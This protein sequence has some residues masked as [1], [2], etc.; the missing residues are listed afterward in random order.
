M[1][2]FFETIFHDLPDDHLIFL[3]DKGTKQSYW[4]KDI[5]EAV[6]LS[7]K[8]KDRDFYVGCGLVSSAFFEELKKSGVDIRYKRCPSDK[9]A[10]IPAFWID[11]DVGGQDAPHKKAKLPLT[12]KDIDK[13]LS[14]I[15]LPPTL[16]VDSGHGRHCWWVLKEPW[17]F[18]SKKEKKEGA[19]LVHRFVATLA[20]SAREHGFEL[21]M[22]HD[23][24][25]LL[26]IPGTKNT[27][28]DDI[29]DVKLIYS[30]GSQYNPDD[31]DQFLLAEV[32]KKLSKG[33]EEAVD[34]PE[35][36]RFSLD[37][38]AD[39]PV[40]KFTALLDAE[41]R[42]RESWNY[43]RKD[44]KDT[45][46]SAYDFSLVNFALSAGWSWQ[47]AVNLVIAFRRKHGLD[48]KLRYDYYH[49]TLVNV[50]S[51]LKREEAKQTIQ[52]LAMEIH[53][54]HELPPE[55]KN[56][57]IRDNLSTLIGV[58]VTRL[59]KFLTEPPEY[60]IE[61]PA[62]N[63][64]LGVIRNITSQNLFRD[65]IADA[66]KTMMEPVDKKNWGY[67]VQAL[68]NACEDVD[69]GEEGTD[70][71]IIKA[72]LVMFL[73]EHDIYDDPNIAQVNGSPFRNAGKIYFFANTVREW[74]G[75]FRK[76]IVSTKKMGY[77]LRLF[78]M[79]PEAYSFVDATGRHISRNVWSVAEDNPVVDMFM[80]R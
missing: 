21:D 10:G 68:L 80:K 48:L 72:W 60:R 12:Q 65:H 42:F 3:W 49:R 24:S 53:K 8:M 69:I 57:V 77:F 66:T 1:R 36:A 26:R 58:P 43:S 44:F 50:W 28:T 31:F 20:M 13:I 46:A 39:P 34:L 51:T 32:P 54:A 25:R 16:I 17:I 56:E 45:S 15:P 75:M 9:I 33:R 55:K 67:V 18:E 64:T 41:P 23:L 70:F 76:E 27:K 35:G 62:G 63:I 4:A 6:D 38:K 61:T 7:E 19:D 11:I 37:P 71:G 2:Q 22:T 30:N 14:R 79:K 73:Q 47:E 40:D 5:E 74:L 59:I 29:K 78:G 52:D